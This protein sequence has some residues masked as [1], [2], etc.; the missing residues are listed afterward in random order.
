MHGTQH[1]KKSHCSSDLVSKPFGFSLPPSLLLFLVLL[2][3]FPL[4]LHFPF[5]SQVLNNILCVCVCE[6]TSSD[7]LQEIQI[8]TTV[9][10]K[11]EKLWVQEQ[12]P[13]AHVSTHACGPS[14]GHQGA[15][16]ARAGLPAVGG[17]A[18]RS[19]ASLLETSDALHAPCLV[20]SHRGG[21]FSWGPRRGTWRVTWPQLEGLTFI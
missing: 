11:Q 3:I 5:V 21:R 12:L 14:P 2:L 17:R 19:L 1:S 20:L 4:L 13:H 10:N 6:K 15:H 16:G 9:T 8:E 18:S 7:D